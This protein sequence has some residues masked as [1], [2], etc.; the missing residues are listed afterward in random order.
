[1]E[2]GLWER[3]RASAHDRTVH[4]RLC[5]WGDAHLYSSSIELC[6][7]LAWI[8]ASFPD[9]E[10]ASGAPDTEDA[11]NAA[12]A[13]NTSCAP[14]A[15][16]AASAADTQNASSAQQAQD[17]QKAADAIEAGVRVGGA[18]IF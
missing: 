9:A 18:R 8:P 16:D 17:A 4:A 10:N 6:A 7:L 14:N 1:M 13:Q 15:E 12:D 11:T 3:K 2:Y 5:S